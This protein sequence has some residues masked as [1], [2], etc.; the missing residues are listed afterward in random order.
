[1]T[2]HNVKL[3]SLKS[4]VFCQILATDEIEL[5]KLERDAGRIGNILSIY[6]LPCIVLPGI[7]LN[8]VS[9]LVFTSSDLKKLSSS[10]YIFALLVSDTGVLL[11]LFIVWLE[12]VDFKINHVNGVCQGLVFSTYTFSFLSVWYVVC[13]TVENY[14]T[15]CHPCR[16]KTMCTRRRATVTCLCVF[17]ASVFLYGATPFA[18]EVRYSEDGNFGICSERPEF[19]RFMQAFTYV[20]SLLTLLVPLIAISCMLIGLV[21]SIVHAARWKKRM[22]TKR[23]AHRPKNAQVRV[24]RMLFALSV[25][26][27]VMNAPSHVTR[28]YYLIRT[29]N[30]L[31][32]EEENRGCQLTYTEGLINLMLQYV[33]YAHSAGKFWIFLLFS[34]NFTKNLTRLI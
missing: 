16:I 29:A 25:S 21:L 18:A 8:G 14:I 27:V 1:M 20:D 11:G 3:P 19:R 34:K 9:C 15:I 10:V 30:V 13:V 28:L 2:H 17:V 24:T 26:Y 22:G 33:T 7:L 5:L 12:A 6:V 4:N 31:G 23:C 32:G